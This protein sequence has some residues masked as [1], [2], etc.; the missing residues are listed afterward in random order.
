[1]LAYYNTD[2]YSLFQNK[3]TSNKHVFFE[4]LLGQNKKIYSEQEK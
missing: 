4:A 1:M 2:F 3:I